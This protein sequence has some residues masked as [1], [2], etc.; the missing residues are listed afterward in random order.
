[1]FSA[2]SVLVKRA[3]SQGMRV[4][5]LIAF[6]SLPTLVFPLPIDYSIDPQS[7]SFEFLSFKAEDDEKSY[8]EIFCQIPTQ[9]LQFVSSNGEFCASY[10]LSIA[11][12]DWKEYRV[13]GSTHRDTVK[14]SAIENIDPFKL[15]RF[16]FLVE[17]GNYEAQVRFTDL[18]SQ[19]CFTFKKKLNVPDYGNSELQLSDLQIASS[20]TAADEESILVKNSRKIIP[21]VPRIFGSEFNVLY[22]YAEIYNLCYSPEKLNKEFVV[23]FTVQNKN[24][25]KLKS[26]ELSYDKPG[27]S[28][29]L[30]VGI[31]IDELESGLY[32]LVLNVKDLDSAQETRKSTHF[33]I[34]KPF[35]EFTDKEFT[36]FIR[37]LSYI[38]S[39]NELDY[40]KSL[41]RNERIHGIYKFWQERDPTPGTEQN[42]F[43]LEYLRRLQ[44]AN[45]HFHN[46]QGE[47]WETDQ[48]MVYIKHGPPDY[49]D[50]IASTTK[51]RT[52]EVWH[53]DQS[54]RKYIFV[55]DWG[56]GEFRLLKHVD[57]LEA[58][59]TL[60]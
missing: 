10:E 6:I 34:V 26:K 35:F 9:N 39:H 59:F 29:V 12:F 16:T 22:V 13:V 5:L 3:M 21:N 32:E 18:A 24:G 1:M 37:Q 14:A 7:Y 45:E 50:H 42:E 48:G 4:I 38:A 53:Y 23:T 15:V 2:L 51:N 44:Y 27:D 19:Y 36:K 41:S 58:E 52:L 33:N 54:N 40:L 55:D 28:C 46:I 57:T 17:S 8:V 31:P 11:L 43:M 25:F 56:L 20:I 30:S 47:G 49:V 60:H